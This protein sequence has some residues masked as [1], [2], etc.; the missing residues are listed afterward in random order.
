MSEGAVKKYLILHVSKPLLPYVNGQAGHQRLADYVL[1]GKFGLAGH[2]FSS[3][4]WV[5]TTFCIFKWLYLKYLYKHLHNS[6][7]LN[8]LIS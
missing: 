3:G 6:L 7:H 5:K 2:F 1:K 8:E 4:P